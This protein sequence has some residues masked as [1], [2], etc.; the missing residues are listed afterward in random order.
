MRWQP[1]CLSIPREH[2]RFKSCVGVGGQGAGVRRQSSSPGSVFLKLCEFGLDL[3]SS[4]K[5][6]GRHK[7][8]GHDH[9]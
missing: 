9:S 5:E 2:S 4:G 3:S 1:N 8:G 6:V 7:H